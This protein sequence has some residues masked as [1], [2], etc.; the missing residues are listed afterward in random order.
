MIEIPL[1]P[2]TP[3]GDFE[4]DITGRGTISP[5]KIGDFGKIGDMGTEIKCFVL[6]MKNA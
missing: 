2:Q 4:K 3:F 6:K 5:K 1:T